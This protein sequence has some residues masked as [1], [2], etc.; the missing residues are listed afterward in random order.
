MQQISATGCTLI[1]TI[2]ATA[3]LAKVEQWCAINTGTGNITGLSRQWDL[4]ADAFSALPG[5]LRKIAPTPTP[6]TAI[7]A[8]G[9]EVE[10]ANGAHLVLSV[11]PDATRRYLLT[12]HMDTVFAPLHPFQT[13]TWLDAETLNGPGVADMKGGIAVILAALTAFEASPAAA[14]VGYDVLINADEE[15]GSLSSAPFIAELARLRRSRLS[16]LPYPMAH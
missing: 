12:G 10:T 8:D 5:T 7:A 11:R 13:L 9:Q 3:M 4:L 6:A 2:D 16:P 14:S 1:A 15:T